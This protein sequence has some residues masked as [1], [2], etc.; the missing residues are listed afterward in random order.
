MADDTIE[1]EYQLNTDDLIA[2]NSYVFKRKQYECAYCKPLKLM[3]I[4]SV[5]GA[6]LSSVS[7]TST[8]ELS[9]LSFVFIGMFLGVVVL[10]L[11]I[12][13][14]FENST[15]EMYSAKENKNLHIFMKKKLEITSSSIKE[16][17]KVSEVAY[18]WLTTQRVE[19]DQEYI[20]VFL[21]PC[22]ASIIPKRAFKSEEEYENFYQKC[23]E[24]HKAAEEETTDA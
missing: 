13:Y 3:M 23:V 14:L 6:V 18:Q 9:K 10:T 5:A 4:F 24:Y 21:A 20:F 16:K 12:A 22:M 19:K 11:L 15:K 2:F 7:L 1:I 8:I 17:T